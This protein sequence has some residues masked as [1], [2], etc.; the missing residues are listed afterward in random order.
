MPTI[1]RGSTDSNRSTA[2]CSQLFMVCPAPLHAQGLP[3][4]E[5]RQIAN[6]DDRFSAPP[7]ALR[8]KLR[9]RIKI[10]LVG[11]NNPFERPLDS[12]QWFIAGPRHVR[13]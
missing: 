11:I 9:N 1:V 3:H 2:N 6:D 8:Q 12:L 10:L 13:L 7:P 5:R 4:I